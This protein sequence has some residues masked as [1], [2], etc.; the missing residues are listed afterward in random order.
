MKS[1]CL[2]VCLLALSFIAS[3]QETGNDAVVS[4]TKMNILYLGIANPVEIAVPGITSDKIS[5]TVNNGTIV[6]TSNGWE[7]KPGSPEETI[8][9]V[10]VNN[11][12]VSEKLFRVKTIPFPSAYFAGKSNGSTSREITTKTQS[13]EARLRDFDWDLK[14]EVES[15]I[16]LFLKDGSEK[17]IISDGNKLTEEMK[18]AISDLKRGQY[19]TFKDIKVIA[20]DGRKMDLNP[21]I[22]K[23]D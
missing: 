12:K 13:L 18:V 21:L 14:F 20:P 23:L 7:V 1:I 15:F 22:L 16:L 11:K 19:V 9:T 3:A 6:R 8:I 2:A 5:A 10:F 4:A 17:Q